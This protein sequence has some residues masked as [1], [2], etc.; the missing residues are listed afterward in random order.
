MS[1]LSLLQFTLKS[2]LPW[3][4]ARLNFLAQLLIA[5]RVKTVSLAELASAFV[6]QAQQDSH[7]K[8][9][10]HFFQHFEVDYTLV[11]KLV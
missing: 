8:R 10:Q 7:Y 6:G 5:L 1:E 9:L 4:G 3:H 2:H 11:A